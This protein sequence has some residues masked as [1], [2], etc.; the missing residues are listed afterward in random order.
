MNYFKINPIYT[1]IDIGT[2]KI[3]VIIAEKINDQINILGIGSS[4]S[5]GLEKGVV[6]N[7]SSTAS[8]IKKAIE[9]A[10]VHAQTKVESVIVGISGSHIKSY[11]SEGMVSITNQSISEKTIQE[12]LLASQTIVLP[13]DEKIIHAMPLSYIIDGHH[14]VKNP[15]KM[16]GFRL[17]VNTHLIT[18]NKHA[19]EDIIE[20]CKKCGLKVK[21]VIL[22]PIASAEA[23]LNDQEK[24]FGSLLIDIGGG[25]S[26]VALYR[27]NSLEY[28]Q[29]I[30]I[31]GVLFTNDLAICLN[32]NKN[33]AEEIKKKYGLNHMH[34]DVVEYF[35]VKST[36]METD[37]NISS[38]LVHSILYA[39]A[40]E[41]IFKLIEILDRYNH[42]YQI[43]S[44]IILTGGGALLKGLPEM[45]SK[46]TGINCRIGYPLLKDNT[47]KIIKQPNYA[48]AYGLLLYSI[49]NDTRFQQSSESV[50]HKF[51]SWISNLL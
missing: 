23:I 48:T 15:L 8:S 21:D 34:N 37:L 49:K 14:V 30:N 47:Y 29:I 2:T 31:A 32:I 46:Y 9:E 25:T 22:E 10:Q 35:T 18:A 19:I 51:R 20:C 13:D 33:E 4:F 50:M 41:L 27:N 16:H 26:D 40:E 5:F 36:D 43:P 39:R 17:E 45:I 12:V 3:F 7:I 42:S 24:E 1:I 6:T 38:L 11:F 28:T 44:G